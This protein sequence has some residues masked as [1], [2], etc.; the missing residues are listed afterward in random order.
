MVGSIFT[1]R[2]FGAHRN[3]PAHR[4]EEIARLSRCRRSSLTASNDACGRYLG[5]RLITSGLDYMHE[6]ILS[7]AS[8]RRR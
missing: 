8:R 4:I 3:R 5:E 2:A 1:I 7:L 6:D